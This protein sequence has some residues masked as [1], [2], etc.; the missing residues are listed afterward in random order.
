M[1]ALDQADVFWLLLAFIGS[2][3]LFSRARCVARQLKGGRR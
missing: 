3:Y 1:I 2:Q